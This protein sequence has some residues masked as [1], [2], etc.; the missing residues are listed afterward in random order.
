VNRFEQR[1][2]QRLQNPEFASGYRE[3]EVELQL[4]HAF[5]EVRQ[6]YHI[7]QQELAERMGRKREAIARLLT[8][9]DPNPT[10]NTIVDLLSALHLTADITLR[11]REEGEGAVKIHIVGAGEDVDAE[12]KANPKYPSPSG[13]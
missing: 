4:M 7:T 6:R 9:D 5:E 10:L 11:Q 8:I 1:S 13:V 12:M 2:Q 3:M